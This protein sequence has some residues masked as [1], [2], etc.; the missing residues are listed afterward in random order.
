LPSLRKQPGKR[1]IA[2]YV[3]SSWKQPQ[4]QGNSI[5]ILPSLSL[6]PS[7]SPPGIK[8]QITLY[9]KV[10]TEGEVVTGPECEEEVI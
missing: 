4:H 10:K 7:D 8:K 3:Q 9:G 1:V 6:I 5:S 2:K